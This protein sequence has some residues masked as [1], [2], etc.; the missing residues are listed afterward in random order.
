MR[1]I[2]YR[3]FAGLTDYL[4][5]GQGTTNLNSSWA[6]ELESKRNGAFSPLRK[7]PCR[8]AGVFFFA[9]L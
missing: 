7:T 4:C 9:L 3:N 5:V 8:N 1:R 6:T 2:A